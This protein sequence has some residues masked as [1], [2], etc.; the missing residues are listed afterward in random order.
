MSDNTQSLYTANTGFNVVDTAN[1]NLNGKYGD[2]VTILSSGTHGTLI[3]SVIIK[4]ISPTKN[5]NCSK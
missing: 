5:T 1:P 2:Y 4:C 3:K